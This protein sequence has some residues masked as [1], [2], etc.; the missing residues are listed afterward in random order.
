M[1]FL[2]AG[3]R[4][5]V[6]A[7]C[8]NTGVANL[9]L[10]G[11]MGDSHNSVTCTGNLT[12]TKSTHFTHRILVVDPGGDNRTLTL[13]AE[14]DMDGWFGALI[15]SAD[16]AETLTVNNDAAAEVASVGQ[17]EGLLFGCDGTRWFGI[18]VTFTSIT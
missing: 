5:I 4:T 9:L 2:S 12:L 1:S 7:F 15:N 3:K 13:P 16:N 6:R 10:R 17:N 14:A 11:A 8:A 18:I